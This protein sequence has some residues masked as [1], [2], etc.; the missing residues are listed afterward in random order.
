MLTV[1]FASHNGEGVLP[2]TLAS[3]AATTPPEG[4]W[5]LLAVNNASKD[6]TEAVLRSFADRLPLTLLR[7]DRPGKNN[8]LNRALEEAQGDFYVFCDDDVVVGPDWLVQWRRVADEHSRFDMFGGRTEPLWPC[9][10][11]QWVLDEVDPGIVFATNG[12]MR[13][14]PCDAVALFGTNMAVRASVFSGGVRFN[15]KIGPSNSSAYPMG[16]ETELTLRLE[17]KGHK[18][19]FSAAPK[20]KHIIRP[21]QMQ[22][23]SIAMRG[24]RWGRGQ[25]HMNMGHTYAPKRL[26]RKNLLRASLYP[27][28]MPFYSHHEAW[29]RQWEW[30][31]DQGYED[32]LRELR[33][34]APRWLQANGR[35]HIAHRF[36]A[37]Q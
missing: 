22:R 16:S 6:G 9:D 15:G 4:G 36:R 28:L 8:A 33:G 26:S 5:R 18:S 32:G 17:A 14:G 1:L 19:W 21:H 20:V 35:P 23:Q 24:Y 34:S 3:M 7:E 11:P 31:I 10:P 25:A 12:H 13:E 37:L 29:A 2:S 30:A 27:V